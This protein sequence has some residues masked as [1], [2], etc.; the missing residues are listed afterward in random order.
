[1]LNFPVPGLGFIVTI[2]MVT[3]VGFVASKLTNPDNGNTKNV[4]KFSWG[5]KA[6]AILWASETVGLKLQA[7]LLSAVQA[8]G[9]GFYFGGY[10]LVCCEAATGPSLAAN[11]PG[12]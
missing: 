1:M 12:Y 10:G 3:L 11:S 5:L 7:Q 8:V 4:T 6:G 2:A 9:G